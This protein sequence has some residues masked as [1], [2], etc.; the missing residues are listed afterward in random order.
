MATLADRVALVT[1]SSRGIGRAVVERLAREG[2]QVVVNYRERREAADAVA[3]GITAAGGTAISLGADV[4]KADAVKALV[5]G[6]LQAYGR[7]DILVNNAGI[8]RDG[9]LMAMSEDDWDT[10]LNTN[11]RSVFLVSR[12]VVRPMMKQRRGRIINMTSISGLGGNPGQTNYS[13]AKA[14]IVGF[15]RSLAKEVGS[16]GITVNAV[17]PGYVPTDLTGDLPAALIAEATRLTPLGRLGTV[18]DVAGAVAFLASDSAAFITGQ[19]LR[20][21]GGMMI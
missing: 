21:D 12:A 4:S 16:R 19:V 8:T 17:A 5:D 20:V 2:A 6:T 10:V 15:T 7:L 14:G 3:A 1:G 18:E 11:L 13:A 9:L